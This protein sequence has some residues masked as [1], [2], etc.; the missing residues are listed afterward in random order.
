[1]NAV[2]IKQ[3]VSALAEEPFGQATLCSVHNTE[4]HGR[5]EWQ[6]WKT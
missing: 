4:A 5:T 1:M 2:E 3:T 6:R